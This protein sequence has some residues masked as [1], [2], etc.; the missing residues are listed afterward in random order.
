MSTKQQQ[1]F[2]ALADPTRRLLIEKLSAEGEKTATELARELP[3]TRQGVSKHLNI[4]ARANVVQVRQVGRDRR[5]TMVPTS[6]QIAT[7]W[8]AA[9]TEQWDRRLQALSDYLAEDN[10]YQGENDERDL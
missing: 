2:L 7:D 4:M 5:Y 10:E 9:V 3:F 1:L 8:V 6:L